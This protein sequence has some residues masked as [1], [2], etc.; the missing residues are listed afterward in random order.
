M[1][2]H[3][4]HVHVGRMDLLSYAP[5][6]ILPLSYIAKCRKKLNYIR[7]QFHTILKFVLWITLTWENFWRV[8]AD[9][10][11]KSTTFLFCWASFWLVFIRTSNITSEFIQDLAFKYYGTPRGFFLSLR[12]LKHLGETAFP[13]TIGTSFPPAPLTI[14]SHGDK[15]LWPHCWLE[16]L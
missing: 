13:I 9:I 4:Q 16:W 3:S 14:K 12:P 5:D 15:E 10:S 2:K 8:R 1:L 6:P 7:P 11:R